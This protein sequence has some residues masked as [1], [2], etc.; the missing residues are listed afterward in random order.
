VT[1]VFVGGGEMGALM[2]TRDWSATPLGP[3]GLWPQSLRTALSI[4]LAS[5]YPM[6]IAWGS[7]YIQFYNDA[8]RPILGA[9][10]HPEALG[11]GAR[12]C[13][14][15]IWEIIGPMF[16]RVMQEAEAT[17][18]EDQL[19]PLD[20]YGYV[21]ECYFTF[22]YSAIRDESGRVGGVFVTVVE[23]TQRVL[24]ERRLRTLRELATRSAEARTVEHACQAAIESLAENTADLPFALLYL[25]D[26]DANQA[27]LA[28]A[29]GL[30]LDSPACPPLID[31]ADERQPWP[32]ADVLS[33][34]QARLIDDLPLR[35]GRL[36]CEPWPESPHAALLLPIIIGER[37]AGLLVTGVSARRA[38]D[39]D[40][41][42]F[43]ELVGGHVTTAITNARA[44]DQ[45]R[46]R[47]EALAELD[48]AKTDFF[49]NVSHEFRTPLALLL[50]PIEELLAADALAPQTR[51]QLEI[52]HRNSLRLL[53][54]VNLLLDFS[55]I[56]AGRIDAT[57]EPVDL[58]A[59]TADLASQFRSAIERAGLQLI[60]QTAPLDE[61]VYIDR[62]M[63][64]KIVFNLLSNAFKF[65]FVGQIVVT[66]CAV[67][68]EHGRAAA[69]AVHD[70]GVGIPAA[71]LPHIFE[72][73]HRVR[74]TRARTYE[75]S[76]IGLAL[77]QQLVQLHGGSIQVQSEVGVGTSF[78][79]TLPFGAAHLP[80][81]RIGAPRR[82]RST[83]VQ[84]TAYVEEA[85]RWLPT[86]E[87][88]S[89]L[90]LDPRPAAQA[91][92]SAAHILLVDDNADMRSYIR[93]LLTPRYRVTAVENGAA[94]LAVAQVDP[95][96]L[97]LSD[98]MMPEMDGFAL[99]DALRRDPRT[100]ET[101]L[102]LLSARAGEEAQLEGLSASADDYLAK[103]FS[104]RELLVR[105]AANLKLAELRREATLRERDARSVAERAREQ[106]THV[107]ERTIDGVIALDRE[108]RYIYVNEQ[109][110][111]LARHMP[112]EMLGKRVWELFPAAID[113]TS[114][115]ELERALAEQ[116]PVAFERF[117]EPLNLWIE[118]RA[119]PSV[120]GLTV[121]LHDI[122]AQRQAAERATRLQAVT[123]ALARALT[124]GQV[125]EVIM[126]QGLEALGADA[127]GIALVTADDQ[128]ALLR[129]QGYSEEVVARFERT[130]LAA[131]FPFNDAIRSRD[132]I[133][134]QSRAEALQR[135]PQLSAVRSVSEYDSWATVPL[136]LEERAIGALDFSFRQPRS[137]SADECT[138]MLTLAQQCAQALERARLYEAERQARGEAESA[139][140]VRD[141]FLS[142]ASHELKTPLTA[143]LGYAQL[144]QQRLSQ[145]GNASERSQ[146]AVEVL[147]DQALRLNKLIETLL[148]ISRIQTGQLR[149]DR[150]PLDLR[151]LLQRIAEEMQLPLSRH[152]IV[153][154]V[155]DEPLIVEAD[156]LRL[157]Q[158]IQNLLQNAIK[159]S[160]DGG[161]ITLHA[162]AQRPYVHVRITDQGMGIPQAAQAR[163]FERFY[164]ASNIDPQQISGLGIGLYVVQEIVTLHGGVITVES[165]EHQGSTFTVTLPLLDPAA[166][167][168]A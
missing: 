17:W 124:P 118:I 138:F 25:I 111:Q 162:L 16:A 74:D 81:E 39:D 168:Q 30:P 57:Y 68:A 141:V 147:I 18:R 21:E 131:P 76:G 123:A 167:S 132:L 33:A 108:W 1:D 133:L 53:K 96:D 48:R 150:A 42:G 73:F 87:D 102:I 95:P 31:P 49:S 155:P 152:E 19:L 160:P 158:V 78:C 15:E 4:L 26:P 164:R 154:Y 148:D 142:I 5:G 151:T 89:P 83:A 80:A 93:R 156:A 56:E 60:V 112:A 97:V 66:V 14:A 165:A 122:T 3:V 70:T 7:E 55:R 126:Q 119:Y 153:C 149:L 115:R 125:A 140:H 32:L 144:L 92:T 72:R 75:G 41:R 143:L 130:P 29:F 117:F 137:F 105:V 61:P 69:L 135:Y 13:F 35:F 36:R 136:I 37:I 116:T 90:E 99:L 121:Y 63:W 58:A 128:V 24:S 62:E 106:M 101:P 129:I 23:T 109:A 71:E 34:G 40:Y 65:T 11:Q 161:L 6:Y 8:Y 12:V 22:S 28:H 114:S 107:F 44:Y 94:A 159:Y 54:L 47:A 104:A 139:L 127:G 9:T 134:I 145:A 120:D 50:G 38:L 91:A 2:R 157:E 146:R 166:A 52:A 100:R 64:E 163:L 110:A 77:V 103:P 59:F 86:S 45:E 113:H 82:A 51:A 20:R 84:A 67:R 27:R 43:L 10:K 79:I 88:L 46:R 98:V 85:L